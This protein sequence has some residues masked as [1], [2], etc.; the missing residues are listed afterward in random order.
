MCLS[1][2]TITSILFWVFITLYTFHTPLYLFFLFNLYCTICPAGNSVNSYIFTLLINTSVSSI[3]LLLQIHISTNEN[4]KIHIFEANRTFPSS[5]NAHCQRQIYQWKQFFAKKI[6]SIHLSIHHP[7]A[8]LSTKD[9][10]GSL[11]RSDVRY[12]GSYQ[13]SVVNSGQHMVDGRWRFAKNVSRHVT[14]SQGGEPVT[15]E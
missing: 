3:Y 13:D 10:S 14:P 2:N 8:R 1:T 15:R 5:F 4:N 12:S 9:L 11:L 6:L 7:P